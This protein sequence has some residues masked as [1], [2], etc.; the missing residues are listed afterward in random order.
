MAWVEGVRMVVGR[1]KT[2]DTK[3]LEKRSGE[4]MCRCM[5]LEM[6]RE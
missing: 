1:N 5:L 2:A 3:M 6:K 4:K